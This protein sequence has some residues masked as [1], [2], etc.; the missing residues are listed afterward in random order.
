MPSLKG[1]KLPQITPNTRKMKH[2]FDPFS[3]D[4]NRRRQN[5]SMSKVKAAL[6]SKTSAITIDNCMTS[7]K[8]SKFS[9]S[10]NRYKNVMSQRLRELEGSPE[11]A[12]RQLDCNKVFDITSMLV[13]FKTT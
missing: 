6:N 8:Y 13:L 9:I 4:F 7:R 2:K 11:R 3:I 10:D 12:P 5:F 1:M